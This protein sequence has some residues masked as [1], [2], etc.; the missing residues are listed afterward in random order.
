MKRKREIINNNEP[1]TKKDK[2]NYNKVLN[3]DELHKVYSTGIKSDKNPDGL[4][5][6]DHIYTDDHGNRKTKLHP[7]GC[8]GTRYTIGTLDDPITFK[9]KKNLKREGVD[10]NGNPILK[11]NNKE[12]LIYG[13]IDIWGN[14]PGTQYHNPT[15]YK[16]VLAFTAVEK[17]KHL[18]MMENTSIKIEKIKKETKEFKKQHKRKPRKD[19]LNKL[20]GTDFY[21]KELDVN[22]LQYKLRIITP[23][24]YK[25]KEYRTLI[26]KN[27]STD[28][29]ERFI[30]LKALLKSEKNDKRLINI[31]K[32][33]N[34][35]CKFG[36]R[37]DVTE[38]KL[39]D[40][41]I[42][43]LYSS[44]CT[45]WIEGYLWTLNNAKGWGLA[46]RPYD[47]YITS[48]GR[49]KFTYGDRQVFTKKMK[50]DDD[51]DKIFDEKSEDEQENINEEHIVNEMDI[52]NE[53]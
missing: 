24:E 37:L 41:V 32:V 16:G 35:N 47:I 3:M 43:K 18:N 39:T 9:I 29:D 27:P 52:I 10:S 5:E 2:N 1:N 36:E 4:I 23:G 8:N 38:L 7:I 20:V 14:P 6:R 17:C 19:E 50:S 25:E 28:S 49:K 53:E 12:G 21:Y 30:R 22:D 26:L 40:K 45:G 34:P 11:N 31:Y 15:K 33:N 48:F 51:I 42:E 44:S 13:I 46:N